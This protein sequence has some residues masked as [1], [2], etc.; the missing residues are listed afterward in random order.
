MPWPEPVAEIWPPEKGLHGKGRRVQP[1][2][3]EKQADKLWVVH[4][5]PLSMDPIMLT[6]FPDIAGPDGR[7]NIYPSLKAIEISK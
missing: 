6:H 4:R 5:E 7:G 3:G 1:G 2:S